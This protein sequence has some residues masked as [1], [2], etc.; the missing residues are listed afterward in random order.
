M[1]TGKGEQRGKGKLDCSI[2]GLMFWKESR[3]LVDGA[4]PQTVLVAKRARSSTI[5][6]L[7]GI[8]ILIVE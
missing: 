5:R 6:L 4:V 1:L 2:V 7:T 8:M 3:D